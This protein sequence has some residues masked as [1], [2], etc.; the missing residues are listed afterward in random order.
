[1]I[2][3]LDNPRRLEI[4]DLLAQGPVPVEYI[5]V[6]TN[7]SVANASQHLQVLKN[8]YLVES[9]RRGKY[10]Y[11][12]LANQQVFNAWCAIR[13]LGFSQNEE[14]FEL[15]D[16]FRK[17]RGYLKTVSTEDLIKMIREDSVVVIDVRPEEE[18]KNGHIEN[19]LSFPRKDLQHRMNELPSDREIV[20][21]CR[22]PLCEMA[23][24]AVEM[25]NK[26]G[27]S[28]SR[29]EKGYPDWAASQHPTQKE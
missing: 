14:I 21:Y 7:L 4:L 27:Y 20:A 19:A 13:R 12:K 9:E 26:N 25:L 29:L 2:K 18:F 8:S 5:A 24:D 23:D 1:M 10:N 11:Y 16:S 6:N 17:E 15:L 22:G 28:A 3:A